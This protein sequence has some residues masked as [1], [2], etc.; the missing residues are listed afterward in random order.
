MALAIRSNKIWVAKYPVDFRKSI[1]GLCA[2]LAEH[3]Q[4]PVKEYL[5]LFYNTQRN[6]LKML[7]WHHNGFMLIYKRL[8][9]GRFPFVFSKE[10][11]HVILEEKQLQGL[12]LG[13]D[14]QTIT[15]WEGINFENYYEVYR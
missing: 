6:R 10:R 9:K 5:F 7:V 8:E 12:L 4:I 2:S 1:D 15:T 13:L 14:W 11:D 3:G